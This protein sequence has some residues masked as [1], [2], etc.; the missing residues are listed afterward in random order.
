MFASKYMELSIIILREVSQ[1]QNE[2][3]HTI[4]VM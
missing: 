2:K 1:A 3:C 4:S